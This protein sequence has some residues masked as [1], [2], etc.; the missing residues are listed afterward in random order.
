MKYVL[1]VM[2]VDTEDVE[3]AADCARTVSDHTM[4]ESFTIKPLSGD[5]SVAGHVFVLGTEPSFAAV[6]GDEEALMVRQDPQYRLP[7]MKA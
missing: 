5:P 4:G 3:E 6:P 7:G 1:L 2:E